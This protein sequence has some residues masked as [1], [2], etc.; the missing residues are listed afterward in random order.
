MIGVRG[1][2]EYGLDPLVVSNLYAY[3]FILA[4]SSLS[5]D[6]FLMRAIAF[7]FSTSMIFQGGLV[8]N[9]KGVEIQTIYQSLEAKRRGDTLFQEVDIKGPV[10]SNTGRIIF[11]K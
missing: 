3:Q 2:N 5:L 1:K 11:S 4:R 7:K 10:N 8:E 6:G 9:S